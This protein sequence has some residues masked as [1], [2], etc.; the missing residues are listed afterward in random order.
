MYSAATAVQL[1]AVLNKDSIL[2]WPNPSASKSK[3][4]KNGLEY[5]KSAL[6]TTG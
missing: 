1:Y 3:S 2:G 4:D 6:T 5:Y